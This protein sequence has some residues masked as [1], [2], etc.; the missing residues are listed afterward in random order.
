ME[1]QKKTG[2]DKSGNKVDIYMLFIDHKEADAA[3]QR[4]TA[5]EKGMIADLQGSEKVSVILQVLCIWAKRIEEGK[6]DEY[7]TG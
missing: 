6:Y 4:M 1:I 3:F 2:K 5:L 7:P